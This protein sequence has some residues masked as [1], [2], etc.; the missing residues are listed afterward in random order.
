MLRIRIVH[1]VLPIVTATAISWPANT[2]L[3]ATKLYVA[4]DGNDTWSGREREPNQ[5]RTNG[6]FATLERARDE[7]RKIK[8]AGSLPKGGII[9][10]VQPGDYEQKT[11]L[12]LTAQDSGTKDAPII[13]RSR[14]GADASLVGGKIVTAWHRV[15]DQK[16]LHRM[17]KEARGKVWQADMKVQGIADLGKMEPGPSW[18]KSSPGLEVFFQDE[19]MTLARWPNEGF[20]TIPEVRGPTPHSIHGHGGCVEGIFT[21]DGGRPSRWTGEKDVMLHGYW[22]FDWADQR[23]KVADIDAAKRVITLEPKPQHA[24]G[25]RKGMHYYAYNLLPEL[26]EPGEWYLDRE[27]GILYFWPPTE[28]D[29]KSSPVSSMLEKNRVIVSV[30]P[31]L[32]R[33]NGV[34][35]VTFRDFTFECSRGAAISCTDVTSVRVASCTVRNTGGWGIEMTG[36]QS[37]VVGCDLYNMADGGVHIDGGHRPTLTPGSMFVDNCHI[38][39]FSRWNP[40]KTPGVLV[41]GVGN[42]V[43]HC[44]VNDAPYIAIMWSGNDH[45]FEFNE[46][47][48]VVR[49]SNDSGIMYSGRDA[50][51]RGNVIRYNYLHHVQGYQNKGCIGV[52]LDDMYSSVTIFGNV[53]YK[54]MRSTFI[55]GGHDNVIENNVFVDCDRAVHVDAR[56]TNWAASSMPLILRNLEKLP[57]TQEPW[58]TRFPQLLSYKDNNPA[59]PRGNLVARNICWGGTWLEIDDQAKPGVTFVDNLVHEDPHFV[60]PEHANFQLRADSPAWKTGFQ[61]IPIGKIGLYKDENRVT[62]PDNSEEATRSYLPRSVPVSGAGRHDRGVS[63]DSAETHRRREVDR[64]VRRRGQP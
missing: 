45:L 26:D 17:N 35:H 9:V 5:Q 41:D 52:Y 59:M 14:L 60:D 51:A 40:T 1:A 34:S 24:Y 6:P 33:M 22:F 63:P 3:P 57:Y 64:F 38:Y 10:E 49:G 19:P 43:V 50:A 61:R 13:Y 31:S 25:F 36:K 47:H 16:T 56:A 42:R 8:S 23:L 29:A 4:L 39:R 27:A 2:A 30:L 37:G 54:V 11:T 53:F 28:V 44:L 20:V 46:M 55:G 32:V 18:G 58:R 62:W 15:H 7:I 12:E 48:S 21:Y